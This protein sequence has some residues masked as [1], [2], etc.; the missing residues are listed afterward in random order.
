MRKA[1]VLGLI[2]SAALV[3]SG[4]ASCAALFTETGTRAILRTVSA[5][6]PGFSVKGSKGILASG[7][8]TL[9]GLYLKAGPVTIRADEASLVFDPSPGT[10]TDRILHVESLRADGLTVTLDMKPRDPSGPAPVY[11]PSAYERRD[12]SAPGFYYDLTTNHC[13]NLPHFAPICH[14]GQKLRIV[15]A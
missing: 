6:V 14:F 8:V 7:S 3:L 11:P 13:R 5:L 12:T 10:L 4:A 9:E 2:A 1:R 15:C